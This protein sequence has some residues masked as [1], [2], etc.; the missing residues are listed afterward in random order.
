MQPYRIHVLARSR[1]QLV[2]IIVASDFAA[3]R[4]AKHIARPEDP[5]QVWRGDKCIFERNDL[6][7]RYG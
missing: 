3:V 4:R 5:L 6:V 7:H 1:T 2:D